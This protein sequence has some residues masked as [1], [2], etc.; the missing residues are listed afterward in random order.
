MTQPKS[1][2]KM[3]QNTLQK[4]YL[5]LSPDEQLGVTCFFNAH[6]TAHYVYD[7]LSEESKEYVNYCIRMSTNADKIEKQEESA[8]GV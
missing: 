5:S 1:K 3:S 6:N 2:I 8:Q 7:H 4:R